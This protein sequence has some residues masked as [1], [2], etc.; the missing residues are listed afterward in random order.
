MEDLFIDSGDSA[1]SNMKVNVASFCANRNSAWLK[2]FADK[3]KEK[4]PNKI[5]LIANFEQATKDA[6]VAYAMIKNLQDELN[7]TKKREFIL[8]MKLS[9]SRNEIQKLKDQQEKLVDQ[10]TV[11]WERENE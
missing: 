1:T 5:E 11:Y 3:L 6:Q 8:R 9:L 4:T 10:L 2:S 7:K